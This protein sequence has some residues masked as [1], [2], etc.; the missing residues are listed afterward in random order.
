LEGENM[1]LAILFDI[2]LIIIAGIMMGC[3]VVPMK[4]AKRWRWENIWLLYVGFGQVVFPFILVALT[5][6]NAWEIFDASKRSALASAILFGLGWGVGNVLAGLGYTMLGVGLGLSVVLG[7]TAS[8][9]SLIP[10]AVLF[11]ERLLSPSALAL[12]I[13]V[14][15]M[16]GGLGLSSKAGHERQSQQ[17]KDEI[18]EGADLSAFGK[19]NVRVGLIVCIVAGLLSS[20]L[21]LAFA[22]GDDVRLTALRYGASGS[23]AVNTLW[24]PVLISGFLPT[25]FYCVYLLV[26]NRSWSAF[27]GSKSGS[28]WGI[29]ALMGLLFFGALSLYGIGSVRLG[30]MGPVLGFPIFMSTIVLTGNTAGLVTG[31]WRGSPKGAFVYGFVGMLLLIV[32][33]VIIAVGNSRVG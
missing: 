8:I 16:V 33:I 21:N 1:S 15:V 13:G 29:G 12:Y 6:P 11:P 5:V 7:L 26:K 18:T 4:Y 9:G 17:S 19:G 23:G 24:L 10:L 28:H 3:S 20:M 22:F 25:L 32:S 14:A 2:G 30:A 31:E 27:M